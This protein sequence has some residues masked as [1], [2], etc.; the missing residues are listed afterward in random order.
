[1]KLKRQPTPHAGKQNVT[2]ALIE[3]LKARE[4]RGLETYGRPL[5]TFNGRDA[6]VDALEEALDLV[7]YLFQLYLESATGGRAREEKYKGKGRRP[8]AAKSSRKR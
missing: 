7:Q 2:E 4:A 6:K 8:T 5:E 1:M 3:L